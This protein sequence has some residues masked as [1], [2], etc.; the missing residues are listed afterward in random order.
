MNSE[1]KLSIS[2]CLGIALLFLS[3]I[4]LVSNNT[5]YLD[6]VNFIDFI[7]HFANPNQRISDFLTRLFMVDNN[8]MAVIPKLGLSLQYLLFHDINFK[9]ILLISAFQLSIIGAWF[10]WQFKQTSKPFWM[11]LPLRRI[12]FTLLNKTRF[13]TGFAM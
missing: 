1:P 10:V 5:P 4:V 3:Q 7:L 2:L 11:A 13:L 12:A 8:H 9:R 6:D